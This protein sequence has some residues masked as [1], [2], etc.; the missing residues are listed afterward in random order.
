LAESELAAATARAR[1]AASVAEARATR[2]AQLQGSAQRV[3]ALALLAYQ[4][5]AAALPAVLEAQR[6]ARESR[7]QYLDDVASARI[8][9]G[10]VRLLTFSETGRP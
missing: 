7:A 9:M 8:T 2:S 4:E 3:A 6:T 1:R 5:G 10:L